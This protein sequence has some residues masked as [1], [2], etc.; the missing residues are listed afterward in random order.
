[1]TLGFFPTQLG[2]TE[3]LAAGVGQLTGVVRRPGIPRNAVPT[4]RNGEIIAEGTTL[5]EPGDL[6]PAPPVR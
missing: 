1:M 5:I 6:P 2:T 3:P 4:W